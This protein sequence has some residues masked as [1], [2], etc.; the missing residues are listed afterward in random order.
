MTIHRFVL[1]LVPAAAGLAV[2]IGCHA[3]GS[4]TPRPER[5]SG[6]PP[7]VQIDS[8]VVEGLAVGTAPG[9]AAFQGI[10]YAGPPTG[11]WRWKPPRAVEPWTGIR[12][13]REPGPVCPQLPDRLPG[14]QRKLITALGGDPSVVPP[15]GPMSEDCLS[16][17][18]WT[19]DLRGTPPRPVIVW[20]HGG[21]DAVGTGGDEPASLAPLGVVVVTINYRLGLLGFMAHPALTQESP[22]HAS[23]NYGLLDQIQA[24]HWVQRNI[25]A[26]G[27][28]PLRVTIV[29]H[30]AG[31]GAVLQLLATPLAHGLFHRA[32]AQSGTLDMSQ[33]LAQAEAEGVTTATQLGV[34]ANAPLPALRATTTEQLLAVS[35]T[36]FQ[37]TTDGWAIPRP[38]PTLLREGRM[39]PL[40]LIIGATAHEA[41]LFGFAPPTHRD[42]YLALLRNADEARADR[43]LALY[44]AATDADIPQAVRRYL[45]DRDFVCP[46]RYVAATRRGHTWLYLFSAP[47]APGARYAAFHGAELRPLFD[48]NLGAPL[49]DTA[50]RIGAAM[51]RYWV[52]F[53]TA[54]D[55]NAPGLPDWPVYTGAEPRH[56]EIGDPVRAIAGLGRPACD[57]FDETQTTP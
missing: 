38:V 5:R 55:P 33:P 47:P 13:A 10:P 19:D 15:L 57:V 48:L 4:P 1:V 43:V 50:K 21:S 46:A 23:G 9:A 31:G 29:G 12:A 2:A 11:P 14:F 26:F 37:G 7:R 6:L 35:A 45:T 40:P 28:D 44:P 32:I 54:G 20:L 39:D 17:N 3:A 53:A 52:Q 18:V 22:H 27:G 42:D 36:G 56:L 16:L 49:D 24:L 25:A 34:P 41:D 8:G 30:S 51:R